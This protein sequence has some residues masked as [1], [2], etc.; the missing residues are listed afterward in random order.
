M[1]QIVLQPPLSTLEPRR[2]G[3]IICL[4]LALLSM[5]VYANSLQNG[6]TYD[7][8]AIV[9]HNEQVKSLEWTA[10]WTNNYWSWEGKKVLRTDVLY[11]PLTLWTYLASHAIFP[12]TAWPQHLINVLL[13]GL[14]TV[15]GTLLTWRIFGNRAIAILTGLLFAVHPIHT[16]AVSNIVGRAELLSV[17]FILTALLVYLPDSPIIAERRPTHRPFWHGIL[18]AICFFGMLLCKE[19]PVAFLAG[20]VGID[21]WRW[22]QWHKSDRPTLTLWLGRQTLRY[23]L[24]LCIALAV[25]LAMRINACGFMRDVTLIHSVVN[26]LVNATVAERLIT[27]FVIFAKYLAVTFWP[28]VLSADYSYP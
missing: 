12:D 28:V 17:V 21:I 25:Y 10:I 5:L 27:P 4:L 15:L 24:P 13:H 18:V 2:V 20:F 3:S 19:T 23:Y 22:M 16:E 7:D 11:R 8:V 14:V 9:Q 6:F 1:T 26:P